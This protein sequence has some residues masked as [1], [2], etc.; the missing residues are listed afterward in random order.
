MTTLVRRA[1]PQQKLV[2]SMI[3]GA[4]RNVASVHPGRVLDE[5]LARSISKRATGYLTSQWRE[6][7]MA[8]ERPQSDGGSGHSR[9][10]IATGSG[11]VGGPATGQRA[12]TRVPSQSRGAPQK[13]RWRTPL[14]I[15]HRGIGNAVR[16]ARAA[17]QTERAEALIDVLRVI[18]A[19][20]E[21]EEMRAG[22]RIRL[23]VGA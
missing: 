4:C 23:G 10:Q 9:P 2:M 11:K 8:A 18:G 13:V 6:V 22:A 21:G 7:L 3:E 12:V 15:L 5:K 14:R 16:E 20:V 1:T 19:M 17:G